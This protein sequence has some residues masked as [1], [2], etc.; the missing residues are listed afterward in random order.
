MSVWRGIKDLI[1]HT[2]RFCEIDLTL[3]KSELLGLL[4]KAFFYILAP[5]TQRRWRTK[6]P[7]CRF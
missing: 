3:A 6:K 5:K 7:S 4:M 1:L 2:Y